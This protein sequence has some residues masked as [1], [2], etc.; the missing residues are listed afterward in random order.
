MNEAIFLGF[1]MHASN[2]IVQQLQKRFKVCNLILRCL[3]ICPRAICMA[4]TRVPAM[5]TAVIGFARY[6]TSGTCPVHCRASGN[7]LVVLKVKFAVTL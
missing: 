4:F 5:R 1:L 6:R 7:L 2:L 3:M